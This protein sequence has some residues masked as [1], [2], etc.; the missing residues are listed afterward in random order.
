M[1]ESA[2]VVR[3]ALLEDANALARLRWDF[4]GEE[5]VLDP[6]AFGDFEHAF[7]EFWSRAIA[8]GTWYCWVAEHGHDIVSM[9]YIQLVEMVPRPGQ[10]RRR[11][12]YVASVY[13]RPEA[14][15]Q[16]IGA[17]VL[18]RLIAWARDQRLEFLVLWPSEAS[19]T[20]Y[21]R[22]GFRSGDG[23]LELQLQEIPA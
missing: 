1:T 6:V 8:E 16:G 11:Y 5:T 20:F 21:Q 12:G 14:R 13:T 7:G 10:V 19:I 4:S 22:L 9:A 23:V 3:P 18:H 15:N 17:Q 2:C